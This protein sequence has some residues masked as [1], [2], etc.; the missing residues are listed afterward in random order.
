MINDLNNVKFLIS[1]G[2]FSDVNCKTELGN[3]TAK[4]IEK[5]KGRYGGLKSRSVEFSEYWFSSILNQSIQPEKISILDACSPDKISLFISQH[6]LVEI[7]YQ[8]K[9]FGHGAYC[10][11]NNIL[12][13]W[14]RGVIHGAIQAY[15]NNL[16][17]VYVEQD[18]L[19]FGKD[20]LKNIFIE[21]DLKGKKM[22][23]MNGD[24]TP[25]KIQQSLI[26]VK[27]DYLHK[28]IS[29]LLSDT[30]HTQSEE[31]KHYNIINNE[32]LLISPYR[33]GRQRK[34]LHNEFFCL[35]H[36]SDSE[37][38]KYIQSGHINNIFV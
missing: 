35:Q 12:C 28:Y 10:A 2:W 33:G 22:C 11:K 25:Q 37:L 38:Q 15:I 36:M 30:D 21:M 13:G 24:E 16:D 19:L 18:L 6:K 7:N 3:E 17:F 29:D 9:N 5:G 31:L 8:I 23:Y 34:N 20:F 26:I 32:H 4:H 1:S 27:H 14:A